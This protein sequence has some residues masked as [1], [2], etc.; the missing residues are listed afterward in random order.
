MSQKL[1]DRFCATLN[2]LRGSG[3]SS[4][5]SCAVPCNS[6]FFL[7][8]G[9]SIA[10]S[11]NC[12]QLMLRGRM[13]IPECHLSRL[14]FHQLLHRPGLPDALLKPRTCSVAGFA[15]V[16]LR[17]EVFASENEEKLV[18]RTCQARPGPSCGHR[19][20]IQCVV[21]ARD[22]T[23]ETTEQPRWPAMRPTWKGNAREV[24]GGNESGPPRSCN[25]ACQR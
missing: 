3:A 9:D 21:S 17:E 10:Q 6:R 13:G 16:A 7:S 1:L 5:A 4:G 15:D 18:P 8:S 2:H 25:Q 20:T 11:L 24:R 22:D 12:R 23:R 19:A 14:V